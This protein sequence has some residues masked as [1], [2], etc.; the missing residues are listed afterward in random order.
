MF[1]AGWVA[2]VI[3]E[4]G[5]TTRNRVSHQSFVVAYEARPSL[6]ELFFSALKLFLKKG[7]L[8]VVNAKSERKFS[9]KSVE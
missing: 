7:A 5:G 9:A 3:I 4:Q 2:S 6:K 8:R 1:S